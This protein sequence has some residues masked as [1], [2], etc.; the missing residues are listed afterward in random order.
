VF[1]FKGAAAERAARVAEAEELLSKALSAAPGKASAHV[2]LSYVKS[3]SNRPIQGIAEAEQALA[4]NPNLTEALGAMGTAKLFSGHAEEAEAY[5]QQGFR[6]SPRDP[7]AFSRMY[8]IGAAK[9]H[10][11]AYED[12]SE[13]LVRSVAANQNYPIS[14]FFLAAALGQLGEVE[15]ARAEAQAGLTLNPTFTVSRFRDGAESDDP[16]FLKGRK[17]VYD[18][19]R[20]AGVPE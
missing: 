20:K 19:M 2:W 15:W 3:F 18:G 8:A 6:L 9:L 4:L 11:G 12:A 7:L 1:D 5:H 10:L 14:H 13:W 17:N 16:I